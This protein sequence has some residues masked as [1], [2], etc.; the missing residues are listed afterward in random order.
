MTE[1]EKRIKVANKLLAKIASCGRKFFYYDKDNTTAKFL[2]KS[3]R[4]YYMDEWTKSEM[5]AYSYKQLEEGFSHGGTLQGLVLDI[6]EWIRTGEYTNG[7]NGYGGLF[8]PHWGYPESDMET[9][10]NYAR[11]LGYLR[12]Y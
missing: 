6:S 8:C 12:N 9:I 10:R 11:E 4:V 7:K 1:K 2:L 3:N 5:L